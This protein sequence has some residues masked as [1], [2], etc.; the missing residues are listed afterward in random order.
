MP[1]T[2]FYNMNS[3]TFRSDF[4]TF[5]KI[6]KKFE[7]RSEKPDK[8]MNPDINF[9]FLQD[10]KQKKINSISI[11]QLN[12]NKF[13]FYDSYFGGKNLWLIKPTSYNR[14]RGIRIF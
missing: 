13:K 10:K 11:K 3:S 9:E 5:V 8:E 1:I 7:A 4:N 14:G 12:K 2:F 6:F